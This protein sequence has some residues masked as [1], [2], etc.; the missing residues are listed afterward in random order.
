M[1]GLSLQNDAVYFV[2]PPLLTDG[3]DGEVVVTSHVQLLER[4][5]RERTDQLHNV[6]VGIG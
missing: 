4:G 5:V 3:L 2:A 6:T 1:T